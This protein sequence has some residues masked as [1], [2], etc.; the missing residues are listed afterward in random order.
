VQWCDGKIEKKDWQIMIGKWF[1]DYSIINLEDW[2]T[3]EAGEIRLLLFNTLTASI[4]GGFDG[5]NI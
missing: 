4:P 2:K 1:K 3:K 5:N